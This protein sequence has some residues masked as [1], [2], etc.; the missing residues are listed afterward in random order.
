MRALTIKRKLI[1]ILLALPLIPALTLALYFAENMEKQAV[2][3][4]VSATNHELKQVDQGFTFFIDGIKKTAELLA[5]TPSFQNLTGKLLNLVRG[6]DPK[7]FYQNLQG[8]TLEA[9]ATLKRV[10]QTFSETSVVYLGVEDGGFLVS[11]IAMMPG[12]GFDPRSRSWYKEAIS[13]NGAIVTPAYPSTTGDI[14]VS[15]VAPIMA[16]S[17]SPLGVAGMDVNLTDLSE[18]IKNTTI[19]E[20]GYTILIQKDGTILANPRQKESNFK[21]IVE[22]NPAFADMDEMENGCRELSIDGGEYLATVYSSPKLNCRFIGLI[23]KQEVMQKSAAMWKFVSVS[24]VVLAVLFTLLALWLANGIIQPLNRV[25]ALINDIEK[26]GDLRKRIEVEKEDEIGSLAKLF[27]VFIGKLQNIIKEL[28]VSSDN[29]AS[30]ASLLTNVSGEL[31]D[32]S[33]NTAQ[34][35]STVAAA[36]EEL[37]ANLS[38]V[39]AAMEQSSVN[40]NAVANAAGEMHLTI[41]EIA[42]KSGQAREIST[43][44]VTETREAAAFMKELYEAANRIGKVTEA[45]TEISDQTNLL[46]LNATIEAAR[47]GEA[48]KGFA[49]VA[50]EIKDLAKQTAGATSEISSLVEAVQGTTQKTGH[51]IENIE[52]V[53][54]DVNEIIASIA[55][56]VEE[57]SITTNEIVENINQASLGIQEVN[58]NVSQSS[59]SSYSITKEIAEV[60]VAAGSISE[61]SR[62]LA[63][64]A[65]ELSANSENLQ[66][67]VNKFKV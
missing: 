9:L 62:E 7:I 35:S 60:S 15:V 3:T 27:N 6:D 34:R 41:K 56:A 57:Q 53:I 61:S 29:L 46:A 43:A 10:N 45:I 1:L 48:G 13:K 63:E 21:K 26:S 8:T 44:A 5:A 59:Q 4:F 50:N 31:L 52:K 24:A 25:A 12:T 16:A 2:Q 40:A 65:K 47:A 23:T 37:N 55:E 54:S 39:A 36:A 18:V 51:G 64:N 67:I 28:K 20:T 22:F 58:E 42:G 17:G 30:S 66:E 38:G 33:E 49:V 14:V 11:D 19:G 32:N